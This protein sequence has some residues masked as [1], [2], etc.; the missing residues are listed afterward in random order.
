MHLETGNLSVLYRK[1]SYVYLV[2]QLDSGR[3]WAAVGNGVTVTITA[4]V[5]PEEFWERFELLGPL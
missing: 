5:Q 2:R 4:W 3:D 1:A